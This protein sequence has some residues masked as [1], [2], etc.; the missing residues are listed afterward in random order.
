MQKNGSMTTL[1]LTYNERSPQAKRMIDKLLASSEI[2]MLEVAKDPFNHSDTDFYSVDFEEEWKKGIP[3][4]QARQTLLR[5]VRL[6]G[7][8][9]KEVL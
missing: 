7:L 4:E 6:W 9:T 2:G 1:T 3:V 5:K 8:P